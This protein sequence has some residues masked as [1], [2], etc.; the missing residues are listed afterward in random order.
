M[1][2]KFLEADRD[3]FDSVW[4]K[5]I[6][7]AQKLNQT[8]WK[9]WRDETYYSVMR[10]DLKLWVALDGKTPVAELYTVF[11]DKD[12]LSKTNNTVYLRSFD[13]NSEYR[14]KGIFSKFIKHVLAKM[15]HM[16]YM[17]ARIG[18]EIDNVIAQEIYKHWGFL[19]FICQNS[20]VDIEGKEKQILIF[21]KEL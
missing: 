12:C 4:N 2:I 8:R 17:F 6:S 9:F 5:R 19:K 15:K 18:V 13:I 21:E 20:M 10:N 3:L 1:E 14:G 11:K 16:G 7:S